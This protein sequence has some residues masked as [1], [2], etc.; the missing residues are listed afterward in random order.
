MASGGTDTRLRVSVDLD[1]NAGSELLH[2]LAHDDDFRARLKEDPHGVLAEH[3]IS[4]EGLPAEEVHL[5]PKEAVQEVHGQ[6][7]AAAVPGGGTRPWFAVSGV[8]L[9]AASLTGGGEE[10]S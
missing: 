8:A 6:L 7:A 1:S 2:K 4:V 3:G 5:P 9:L 10:G